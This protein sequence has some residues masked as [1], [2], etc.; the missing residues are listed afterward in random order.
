M[1]SP[2]ASTCFQVNV[3]PNLDYRRSSTP[4]LAG[5]AAFINGH[6]VPGAVSKFVQCVIRVTTGLEL[7]ST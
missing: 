6:D 4:S 5:E 7:V 3:T 2:L 1:V